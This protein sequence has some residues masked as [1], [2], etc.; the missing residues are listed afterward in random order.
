MTAHFTRISAAVLLAGVAFS[1]QP[2]FA[3]TRTVPSNEAQ[4][5]LSFA[6]LVKQTAPAVVNVYAE[7]MVQRRMSPLFSDPFFSRFFGNQMPGRSERQTSLGSGVIVTENGMVIT[8]N[9]V[10]AGADDVR[11]ALSDGREFPCKVLLKDDRYDLAVL[12]IE[13]D[14]DFPTVP[15]GNS[16][17]VEVG[18]LSLAI[19]NPFAVGQTVTSG[20]ISGRAR[21]AVNDGEFGFFL[22]TDAA[23]NPGNSGGALLNMNG[24]LVGIN[25]A[26]FSSGG[27]SNGV[28]FAIPANMVK[29]F[30][31]AAESGETHFQRPYVGATFGPVS[32]DIAEALG[33]KAARGAIVSAI[34]PGSPAEKIG[35]ETGSVITAVNDIPVEHPDALLYRLTVA[36]IGNT[37]DLTVERNGAVTHVALPLALAP[38]D[39]P[40]DTRVIGG[41]SPFSGVTVENISPRV[42]EELRLSGI[43]D[44]VVV[45]NVEQGTPAARIGFAKGDVIVAV[46]GEEVDSTQTLEAEADQE[47]GAWRLT[48]NRGGRMIN[49]IFR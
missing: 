27:G 34:R 48:I 9:H 20:I 5:Q 3:D 47:P 26:I 25:T 35:L 8:N 14:E 22:Q 18:D 13:A 31:D 7:R 10:I 21:N 1:V 11:V 30:L 23:I 24:E 29:V 36:G 39:P 37:A 38:E 40:R 45:S 17:T 46:N 32:S 44:G 15:I 33:L 19:G 4:V 42:A 28:G 6:P 12:K 43:S 49:Q 41:A 2:A 16:D